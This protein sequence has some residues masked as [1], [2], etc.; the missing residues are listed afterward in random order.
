MPQVLSNVHRL[1]TVEVPDTPAE[2][3]SNERCVKFGDIMRRL[4]DMTL[5]HED[6]FWLCKLKRSARSASETLFFKDAPI[7]MEFGL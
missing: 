5:T 1:Q 7:L 3:A 2:V 4:R 6:Y